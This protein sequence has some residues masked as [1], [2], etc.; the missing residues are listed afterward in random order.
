MSDS[1]QSPPPLGE[2]ID[3]EKLTY[4]WGMTSIPIS[5]TPAN[6][7]VAGGTG[8][9]KSITLRL[10]MQSA[11]RPIGL[12][13]DHR[14]LIYDVKGTL[15]P[16]LRGM[17]LHCPI[18]VLN[19]F[20]R[21]GVSWDIAADVT[22]PSAA[23]QLAASLIPWE[24]SAQPFFGDAARDLL[25]AICLSFIK[26]APGKWTL[27]DLLLAIRTRERLQSVLA[28]APEI[29]PAAQSYLDSEQTC[30]SILATLVTKLHPFEAIAACWQGATNRLS[31]ARWLREEG[32]ILLGDEPL[33]YRSAALLNQAI[34]SYLAHLVYEQ[35]ESDARRTWFFLD[36]VSEDDRLEALPELMRRGRSKGVCVVFGVRRLEELRRVCGSQATDELVAACSH[37]TVLRLG[38]VETVEW[39]TRHFGPS[40][41]ASDLMALPLA[42]PE[43][44]FAGFHRTPKA[45]THFAHKPWDW[46]LANLR[47]SVDATQDQ[48]PRLEDEPPLEDWTEDDYKRMGFGKPPSPQSPQERCL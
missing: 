42:S 48:A 12:G 9:G 26:T 21:R 19:P 37:T 13:L 2:R 38:D 24:E 11:L 7:L 29:V 5:D 27:R 10:L 25:A 6:F 43:H 45:G 47:P 1:N 41:L 20:D 22:S 23:R 15:G 31:L 16:V 44:G 14:A 36:E 35:Q 30:T 40:V 18:D 39:A 33:F 46:V 34:I 28:R 32:V 4:L 3:P 17:G 8:S